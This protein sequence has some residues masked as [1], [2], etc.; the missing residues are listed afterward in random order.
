MIILSSSLPKSAST[1]FATYVEDIVAASG[2]RNGQSYLRSLAGGRFFE[3]ISPVLSVCLLPASFLYGTM[4]IKTHCAPNRT[5]RWM[6]AVRQL[7]ALYIYRDPTDVA[8]SAIDHQNR[9]NGDS[10]S[11]FAKFKNLASGCEIVLGWAKVWREWKNYGHVGFFRYE[12][13]MTEPFSV[14]QNVCHYLQFEIDDQA[15][16]ELIARHDRNKQNSLNFNKGTV[17]R[18]KMECSAEE[19]NLLNFKLN[20]LANE[21]GY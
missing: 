21:M 18:Y 10:N 7:K 19:R 12:D 20:G 4:V 1:I 2:K 13:L 15:L 5:V 6:I 16:R 11:P 14:L 17:F 9:L 3:K 8:L